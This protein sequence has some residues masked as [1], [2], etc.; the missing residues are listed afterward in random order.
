MRSDFNSRFPT[1]DKTT[2]GWIGD[3]AHQQEVSG[4]NPDDTAGVKAEYSDADSKQEVR[5]IDVDKDLRDPK[6]TMQS[7][8][9]QILK[10][11]EDLDRLKYII[12]NRTIWSK[13]N[14]WQPKAYTGSNPH[15][16]H[17]HFSGDPLKDEDGGPWSVLTL[18]DDMSLTVSEFAILAKLSWESTCLL[19]D[20]DQVTWVDPN[21]KQSRT[22]VNEMKKR[23]IAEYNDLVARL[24]TANKTLVAILAKLD[25]APTITGTLHVEGD[26]AVS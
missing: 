15:T 16:E 13:S 18:G 26:L 24:E 10:T 11:K 14:N 5:A 9:L 23:Q 7:V 8:I 21:S 25:D 22:T 17:A 19:S 12:Y 1:R 6:L 3:L 4:H 20:L 2:D